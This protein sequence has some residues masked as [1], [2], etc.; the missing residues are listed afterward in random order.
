MRQ[1][2]GPCIV[3]NCK[4]NDPNTNKFRTFTEDSKNK[5]IKHKTYEDYN[6]LKIGDQL[7]HPHY[8]SIVVPNRG[9]DKKRRSGDFG[10]IYIVDDDDSTE[11]KLSHILENSS[12]NVEENFDYWSDININN[13]KDKVSLSNENFDLLINKIK[14]NRY[15]PLPW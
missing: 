1:N 10:E 14:E 11:S 4:N 13:H 2:Y 5:A 3:E 12:D 8:L 9:N 6:Y 15:L 7:C